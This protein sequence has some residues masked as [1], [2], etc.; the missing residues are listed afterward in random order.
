MKG[1]HFA[2]ELGTSAP[3]TLFLG[4]RQDRILFRSVQ[5]MKSFL[6]ALD[7]I[8]W[9]GSIL[10]GLGRN[11]ICED[12]P[13]CDFALKPHPMFKHILRPSRSI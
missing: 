7:E 10:Y 9:F 3:S 13:S 12:G 5:Y 1:V 2:I 8:C 6:T 11:L 4:W